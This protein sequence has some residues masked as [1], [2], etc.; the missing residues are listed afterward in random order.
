MSYFTSK[1]RELA[2]KVVSFGLMVTTFAWLVG[3]PTA[4]AATTAGDDR[5][6]NGTDPIFDGSVKCTKRF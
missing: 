5:A 2:S 1:R 4:G 3:V 6:F